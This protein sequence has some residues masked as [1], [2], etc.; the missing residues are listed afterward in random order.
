MKNNNTEATISSGHRG[1]RMYYP[2]TPEA[3][4]GGSPAGVQPG[5]QREF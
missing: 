1:M 4:V 2:G 5:L 3:E